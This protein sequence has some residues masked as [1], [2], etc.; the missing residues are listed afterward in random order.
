MLFQNKVYREKKQRKRAF[1]I[2][3]T[4]IIL[5]SFIF[6]FLF[7]QKPTDKPE[8]NYQEEFRFEWI[9]SLDDNYPAYTHILNNSEI[10]FPIKS[11][12]INLNNFQDKQIEAIWK[13]EYSPLK[14]QDVLIVDKIK[15]KNDN[16]L[17]YNN[18]YFFTDSLL[19]FDFAND[20][21]LVANK[22]GS[23]IE[24]LFDETN[25]INIEPFICSKIVEWM[26]CEDIQEDLINEN[27]NYFNSANG[28]KYYNYTWDTWI[29]F[30]DNNLWYIVKV[31]SLDNLLNLSH[32]IHTIDSNYIF[33]NNIDK[34]AESCNIENLTENIADELMLKKISNNLVQVEFRINHSNHYKIIVDLFD[35]QK[36][37]SC[38]MIEN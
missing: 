36:I 1:A 26:N 29:M 25:L 32:I 12:L 23:N 30:N 28:N 3:T 24:V 10:Q 35:S 21:E 18:I 2:I 37:E 5:T 4:I 15:N 27:T 17:I 16:I 20:L 11:N 6:L 14:N 7:F 34:I 8:Y 38:T 22:T 9:V 31:N 13:I 19:W 33:A